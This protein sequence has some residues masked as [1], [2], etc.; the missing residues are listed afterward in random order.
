[1]IGGSHAASLVIGRPAEAVAADE[2][3]AL[4]EIFPSR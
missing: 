2:Q 3:Q 4:H 1:M